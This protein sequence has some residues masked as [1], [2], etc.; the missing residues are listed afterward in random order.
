MCYNRRRND[1]SFCD[2][3]MQTEP[4]RSTRPGVAVCRRRMGNRQSAA[5]R[6]RMLS[7]ERSRYYRS[8]SLLRY[9]KGPARLRKENRPA[10]SP[11]PQCGDA[12]DRMPSGCETHTAASR[13][14]RPSGFGSAGE[15][16]A[17]E[18]ISQGARRMLREMCVLHRSHVQGQAK[19]CTFR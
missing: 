3:R 7:G 11:I 16:P 5:R 15:P 17:F 6:R 1:N 9:G 2:I 13:A 19:I 10:P 4:G 18:S 14:S 12:S 8:K